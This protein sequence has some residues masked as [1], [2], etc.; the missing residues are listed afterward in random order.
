M[1]KRTV[2]KLDP[3]PT[4]M[5]D[6]YT[7]GPASSSSGM[8]DSEKF[9]EGYKKKGKGKGGKTVPPPIKKVEVTEEVLVEED[10][11]DAELKEQPV[12]SWD[13]GVVDS[14]DQIEVEQMP[15][16]I[17]V[18]REEKK[19]RKEMEKTNKQQQQQQEKSPETTNQA[20]DMNAA[21]DNTNIAVPDTI[22]ESSNQGSSAKDVSASA[23][24]LAGGIE[25]L[26]I[27][28]DKGNDVIEKCEQKKELTSEEK[29]DVK[30][31]REAKKAAKAAKAAA[32]KQKKAEHS[33]ETTTGPITDP[34]KVDE[35]K[36]DKAEQKAA[37]KAEF[38]AKLKAEGLS[39][40]QGAQADAPAAE[41]K[42]K[43]E[44]KAE[45]RAKQEAQ[46]AAKDG[47]QAKAVQPSQDT[48]VRVS[49]EIKADDK[50]AEKKLEKTLASQKVPAR[51]PVQ[52]QI[53]LFSHLHQYQRDTEALTRDLNVGGDSNIHP[54]IIQLGLQYAE[55][56]VTGSSER[57]LALLEA[58]KCLLVD[59]VANLQQQTGTDIFKEIDNQMKPNITFLKQCRPL[60]VSMG[61]A[62]RFIK[63]EI[64]SFDRNSSSEELRENIV[65]SIE[66]FINVNFVLHPKAISE[67]ANKKIKEGD[68]ILT[69]SHS[70]LVEKVLLDAAQAGKQFRVVVSEARV[71]ALP[72]QSGAK[73]LA[74]RLVRAGVHT[75][76]LLVTALEQVM[77][78][79]TSVLLGCEG[80]MANGCV[81]A[82]V[83]TSQVAL[84][85]SAH[86][87]PVLVCCETYKFTSRVQTDS[88][89]YNELSDP[90]DLVVG[91]DIGP[92]AG[93]KEVAGLSL[94]N[95]VYDLTPASLVTSIITESS[96]IP[97]T[98]VPVILRLNNMMESD[99]SV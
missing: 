59:I 80:V 92:L 21:E 49:D 6:A 70:K 43:A 36:S 79:V 71:P 39:K 15:V 73:G 99:N 48:R 52:K 1:K 19:K 98:S 64:Q 46:R 38:E 27:Q 47:K 54:A 88:F 11:Q 9:K 63:K 26:A 67:T 23:D 41:G 56:K 3:A 65:E 77:D 32:A 17:K 62:I 81:L 50:K 22:K 40:A 74:A 94:L 28:E 45:R 61:N 57:C 2:K 20:E 89:V 85:A 96:Q 93:W 68:V 14:W 5:L 66:D 78:T 83:G 51:T 33:S 18:R 42:S 34:V 58:L 53:P 95:L 24:E 97:P 72:S 29:A 86:N 75:T 12:E 10:E 55:G 84:L 16:P 87:K 31:D 30:S 60:S 7:E 13:E 35:E 91:E 69:F 44:L 8:S 37:R 76:Y 82:T 90:S 25:K 4:G